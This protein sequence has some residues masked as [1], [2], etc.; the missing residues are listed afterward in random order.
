MQSRSFG[1]GRG[2][3]QLTTGTRPVTESSRISIAD[4]L[5]QFRESEDQGEK[6]SGKSYRGIE[7]VFL[8]LS[9][10]WH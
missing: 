3:G 6:I 1:R 2:R 4:R 5:K 9:P 8:G 7:Y 10:H